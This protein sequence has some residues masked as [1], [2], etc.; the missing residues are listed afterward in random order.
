MKPN[1]EHGTVQLYKKGCRCGRC[2]LAM[3]EY[4][5]AKVFVNAG[6]QIDKKVPEIVNGFLS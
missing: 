5:K 6:L 4:A 2:K 3:S 1:F